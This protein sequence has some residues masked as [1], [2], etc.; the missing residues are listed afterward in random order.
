MR[1]LITLAFL[2]VIAFLCTGT[3]LVARQQ[4]VT[5]IGIWALAREFDTRPSNDPSAVT[6]VV[7]QGDTAAS[8]AQRLERQKLI[9]NA[10]LFRVMSK[11]RGADSHLEA[12]EYQL[13][14]NMTTNEIID[15]LQQNR[16]MGSRITVVEGWRVEEIADLLQRRGV[17]NRD[18]FLKLVNTPPFDADFLRSRPAGVSL[19]GYLFPDT[20]RV[21]PGI[22]SDEVIEQ[23]LENFGQRFSPAMREQAARAGLS[24]HQVV[25][26]ASIVER[27]AVVPEERPIIASVYLNRLKEGMLLQA[28]PTVQYAVYNASQSAPGRGDAR[29]DYWKKGLTSADLQVDSPYNTY[30]YK[31]LPPGPIANPGLA[32]IKAVL[33]PANTTYLYFVA[34]ENGAHAFANTLDEH[35]RN[36]EKYRNRGR[37]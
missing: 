10:L 1:H 13:R 34:T 22:T 24:I 15:E 8:V 17:V 5:E 35:N 32:S 21:P 16:F 23:M 37:N 36:V 7:A 2:L 9:S 27:E 14:R 26:L 20:Y 6:F 28:D 29:P 12:G 31:G 4:T 25:T 30:R 18:E 19:E 11:L 33:Q 3:V